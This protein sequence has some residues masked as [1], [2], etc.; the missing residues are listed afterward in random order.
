MK[1]GFLF[2]LFVILVACKAFAVVD[3]CWGWILT[4]M[5]IL[6]N[7]IAADRKAGTF[8]GIAGDLKTRVPL[9]TITYG[10]DCLFN[11]S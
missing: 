2:S 6:R 8:T 5:W 10:P 3:W 1:V 7:P 9:I 4:P 11:V